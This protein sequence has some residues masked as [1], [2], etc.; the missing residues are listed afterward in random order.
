MGGA[1]GEG[2][3]NTETVRSQLSRGS[4]PRWLIPGLGHC[5]LGLGAC[6]ALGW[7]KRACLVCT[8]QARACDLLEI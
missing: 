6:Q 4:A 2:H 3:P 8:W 7:T 1:G 5:G